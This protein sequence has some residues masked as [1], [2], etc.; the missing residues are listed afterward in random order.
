MIKTLA[1]VCIYSADL[2]ATLDFYVGTL[3]LKRK[4]DFI[5]DGKLF[6]FYLE[7]DA[8]HYI[9]FFQRPAE[10]GT[11]PRITHICLET[12]DIDDVIAR[13]KAG[14]Y[15]IR[16]DK[17]KGAD[18]SWQ[19]WTSDPDGVAVEF[20]QYTAESSQYTGADCI[21]NW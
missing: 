15:P 19:C 10:Q 8:G 20:H 1:H 3:G 5:K 17:K 14:G 16:V 2:Q 18:N 4:F 9:E 21:V 7:I 6:G 11:N 12:D 13:L